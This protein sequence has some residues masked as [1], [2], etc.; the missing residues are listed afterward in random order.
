M[1]PHKKLAAPRTCRH[2][3]GK[4]TRAV[5][6]LSSFRH[7]AT[8]AS[9]TAHSYTQLLEL[10]RS[11][12][13][14]R[15]SHTTQRPP[16]LKLRCRIFDGY[17]SPSS[18]LSLPTL[19]RRLPCLATRALYRRRLDPHPPFP[20]RTGSLIFSYTPPSRFSTYSFGAVRLYLGSACHRPPIPISIYIEYALPYRHSYIS[21][22]APP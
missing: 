1:L 4:E 7:N 10:P 11:P 3:A 5:S 13:P 16:L 19:V 2:E 21:A 12:F 9:C 8:C 18:I 22:P 6:V 20:H 17:L 15:P 14:S